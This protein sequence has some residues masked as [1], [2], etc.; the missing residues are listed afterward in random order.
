MKLLIL[1][2]AIMASGQSLLAPQIPFS[3]ESLMGNGQPKL[4]IGTL[5]GGLL[6]P[7]RFFMQQS[8]SMSYA[9]NGT[10]NDMTGLY[11]NKM[12]YQFKVPLT[13]QVDVGFSQKPMAIFGDQKMA[14]GQKPYSVGVPHASLTWQPSDKF[15]MSVHY[16]QGNNGVDN[17]LF[18]D[19][20]YDPFQDRSPYSPLRRPLHQ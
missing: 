7:A 19:P 15:M 16:F 14:E 5:S 10:Q 11:L 3:K 2:F 9:T 8:Y 12:V 17:S 4:G 18:S 13:L 20:Y 1:L 6:D